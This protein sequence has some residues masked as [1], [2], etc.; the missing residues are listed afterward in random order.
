MNDT[1]RL[2]SINNSNSVEYTFN[3]PIASSDLNEVQSIISSKISSLNGIAGT[4]V[5][6]GWLRLDNK[7]IR[8]TSIYI[9][10]PTLNFQTTISNV[11]IDVISKATKNDSSPY[12][13]HVYYRLREV[14]SKSKIYKNGIRSSGVSTISPTD[15]EITN[16]ILDPKLNE[17]ISTRVVV[18]LTFV[19]NPLSV[20]DNTPTTTE[21]GNWTELSIKN[22]Y[23]ASEFLIPL[24]YPQPPDSGFFG[25]IDTTG[26]KLINYCAISNKDLFPIGVTT[27]PE[28]GFVISTRTLYVKPTG[29]RTWTRFSTLIPALSSIGTPI[30]INNFRDGTSMYGENCTD[31]SGYII[32]DDS[33]CVGGTYR[34]ILDGSGNDDSSVLIYPEYVVKEDGSVQLIDHPLI[35]PTFFSE[36]TKS[37]S[38]KDDPDGNYLLTMTMDNEIYFRD[39]ISD[40]S[41][42]V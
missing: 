31:K 5:Q 26:P 32:F 39:I 22:P 24:D 8:I 20:L 15:E 23:G 11:A 21:D 10:H 30:R 13:L 36:D 38:M 42:K 1:N 3:K 14:D 37:G 2:T 29:G 12:Q 35:G 7:S 40:I 33:T 41:K 25:F 9:N 6:I 18:E 17:E 28:Y 4:G 34:I 19:L 27:A 16:N